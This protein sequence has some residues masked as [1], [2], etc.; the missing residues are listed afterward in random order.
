MKIL[1]HS[2]PEA[3]RYKWR[4]IMRTKHQ[5]YLNNILSIIRQTITRTK[6][7]LKPNRHNS[8]TNLQ[9]IKYFISVHYTG[10]SCV[11]ESTYL[12]SMKPN[13]VSWFCRWQLRNISKE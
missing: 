6:T 7:K 5:K 8:D 11:R 9:I 2:V 3:R 10:R 4:S 12:E 1:D 13:Y